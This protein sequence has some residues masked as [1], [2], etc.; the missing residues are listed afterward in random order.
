MLKQ[1]IARKGRWLEEKRWFIVIVE[2]RL[3]VF[4]IG[5]YFTQFASGFKL[6][7][8]LRSPTFPG[9][10]KLLVRRRLPGIHKPKDRLQ[11]P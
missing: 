7:V 9:F 1:A 4:G 2:R 5:F 8:S 3:A 6:N 10:Q 11:D